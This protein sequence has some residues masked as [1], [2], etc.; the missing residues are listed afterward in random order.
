MPT[1]LGNGFF[2]IANSK[3]CGK[4]S[5]LEDCKKDDSCLYYSTGSPQN[6]F[7]RD[8]S[9]QPKPGPGP[10][11]PGPAPGTK[12]LLQSIKELQDLE[13][14]LFKQLE[15]INVNDPT[16]TTEQNNIIKRI[17]ELSDLRNN[18]FEQLKVIYINLDKTADSQR[19]ALSDQ[20]TTLN[21]MESQLT[22]LRAESSQL[23]NAK[24]NKK[25]MVEIGQ[26]EY[27]RYSAHKNVM[28]VIAYTALAILIVS[29]LL[30]YALIPSSLDTIIFSLVLATGIVVV[31]KQVFDIMTRDNMDYDRYQFTDL[32]DSGEDWG[33]GDTVW[34]H[35]AKFF[36]DLWGGIV[37]EADKTYDQW[38]RKG[39]NYLDRIDRDLHGGKHHRHHKN[40]GG[41]YVG[42]G[43]RKLGGGGAGEYHGG[44]KLGGGGAGEYHG[45][46]ES[47]VVAASQKGGANYARFN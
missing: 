5:C 17:N 22:N 23:V 25:R 29:L 41:G 7:V 46:K 14:Y 8:G 11:A 39:K 6:L 9:P 21:L 28:K 2:Q 3:Y 34:E 38:T 31:V 37:H 10:S 32:G 42:R 47:F 20:L 40:R 45:G 30:K 13:E 18:L 35:D 12:N 36:R 19:N 15:K 26:Y 24:M 1:S 27:L 43:G 16:N 4:E 44:R 33:Y